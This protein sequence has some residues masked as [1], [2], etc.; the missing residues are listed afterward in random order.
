MELDKEV[1]SAYE[2]SDPKGEGVD[3]VRE[4]YAGFMSGTGQVYGSSILVAN[5]DKDLLLA[6]PGMEDVKAG[7][8]LACFKK[9]VKNQAD[10][11][12]KHLLSLLRS[13]GVWRLLVFAGDL[14]QKEQMQGLKQFSTSP[15]AKDFLQRLNFPIESFL[16]RASPRDPIDIFDLP[17]MFHPFDE[18]FG[19]DYGRI[20][21][22]YED[23]NSPSNGV[24][25]TT[26]KLTEFVILCRPDQH[27]AWVGGLDDLQGLEKM[28]AT[29]FNK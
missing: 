26:K 1:L 18:T 11:S 3:E 10:G 21:S 2:Q 19:W 5:P 28:F 27:V 13:T 16:V 7:M 22:D 29:I 4:K 24:D 17:E 23:S 20:F 15:L 12:T 6:R 8:R 9:K 25:G 14:R